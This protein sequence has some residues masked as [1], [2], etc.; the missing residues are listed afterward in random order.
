MVGVPQVSGAQSDQRLNWINSIAGTSLSVFVVQ[1]DELVRR[2]FFGLKL[3]I[4]FGF[5]AT[6]PDKDFFAF[7][8]QR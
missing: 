3:G 2:L 4:S 1:V 8:I 7:Q 5:L 6:Q